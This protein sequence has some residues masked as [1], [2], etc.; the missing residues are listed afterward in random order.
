MTA[1]ARVFMIVQV[2]VTV[3]DQLLSYRHTCDRL[4]MSQASQWQHSRAVLCSTEYYHCNPYVHNTCAKAAEPKITR[5]T[6]HT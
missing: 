6:L 5:Q 1:E 3:K 4:C 2:I